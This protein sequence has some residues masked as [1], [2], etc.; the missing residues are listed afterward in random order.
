MRATTGASG[1]FAV[2]FKLTLGKNSIRVFASRP[3]G[4]LVS[5]SFDLTYQPSE[6]SA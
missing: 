2:D 5:K 1:N 6:K 4:E 3:E